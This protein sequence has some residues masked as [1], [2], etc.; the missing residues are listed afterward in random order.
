MVSVCTGLLGEEVCVSASVD[1]SKSK[2][3]TFITD[4][5]NDDDNTYLDYGVALRYCHE[6]VSVMHVEVTAENTAEHTARLA[7]DA[8]ALIVLFTHDQLGLR[9]PLRIHKSVVA[10]GLA[11]WVRHLKTGA[12]V[13][14]VAILAGFLRAFWLSSAAELTGNVSVAADLAGGR[15]LLREA[16]LIA[17]DDTLDRDHAREVGHA[18]QDIRAVPAHRAL[19][20][21]TIEQ[22]G[23]TWFS[24]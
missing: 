15:S 22:S 21:A 24:A 3:N 6:R 5:D 12:T 8:H 4:G 20:K 10:E 17:L 19:D 23:G 16:L 11:V 2:P 1:T 13:R 18:P 7:V 9:V 14:R